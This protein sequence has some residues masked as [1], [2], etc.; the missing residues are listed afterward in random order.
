M[1]ALEQAGQLVP[2]VGDNTPAD[3]DRNII[4]ASQLTTLL[5]RALAVFERWAGTLVAPPLVIWEITFCRRPRG[6]LRVQVARIVHRY[7]KVRTF[8][9]PERKRPRPRETWTGEVTSRRGEGGRTATGVLR[10]LPARGRGL[11]EGDPGADRRRA[12]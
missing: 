6:R 7:Q 5:A 3:E 12:R 2:S 10:D 8:T 4:E 1:R 11:R 9:F